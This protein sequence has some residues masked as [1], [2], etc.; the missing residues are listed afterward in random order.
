MEG[1]SVVKDW[2]DEESVVWLQQESNSMGLQNNK[3]TITHSGRS[4][5]SLDLA[6]FIIKPP[7]LL[8]QAYIG[9]NIIPGQRSKSGTSVKQA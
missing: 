7:Y 9:Y 5:R 1:V 4:G 6:G 2:T 3:T 8:N